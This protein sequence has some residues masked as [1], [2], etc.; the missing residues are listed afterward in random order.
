[1]SYDKSSPLENNHNKGQSG[2]V[3]EIQKLNFV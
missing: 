3:L 2:K 1:M